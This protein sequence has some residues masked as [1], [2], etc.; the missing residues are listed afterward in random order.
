MSAPMNTAQVKADTAGSGLYQTIWRWHFYAGLIC[1]P[2]FMMLAITGALYLYGDRLE[3]VFEGHLLQAPAS[4][5]R[6]GLPAEVLI[7]KALD[8]QPG[9]AVRFTP[10][11]STG[12]SAEVGVQTQGAG[13][14]DVFLDPATG[15]L[16]GKT[17]HE[18]RLMEVI[19]HIHSLAILGDGPNLIIEVVAGW[20]V[21]LVGSGIY[22]W[23][24]RGQ[25]GGLVTLRSNPAR[26]LWWRDLHA[27][28]GILACLVLL[29]LAITGMPW[30]GFWGENYRRIVNASGLG[31][32]SSVRAA[33][34][35]SD[36]ALGA[37]S[38]GSWTLDLSTPPRS[39]SLY[40]PTTAIARIEETARR[41]GLP[42]GYV[43]RLP[44]SPGGVFTLQSYPGPATGQRVIHL[45]RYSGKVLVDVG[46][47]DYGAVSKITEIGIATHT[48]R[49][50]GF[51]NH[52]IMTAGCI[53]ILVMSLASAVMWWKR[54]PD[55][56]LGAPSL[57]GANRPLPG[58]LSVFAAFALA[59]GVL[60]PLLG[61]SILAALI[62]DRLL[63]PLLKR[64]FGL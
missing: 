15:R 59:I 20:A 35:A 46:F 43:I 4:A 42:A 22:L 29:F 47:K 3:A 45:D 38:R 40:A 24:P 44:T 64:Q 25:R 9:T 49:Q 36:A 31:M 51:V 28:T 5:G 30:S 39:M 53:A 57:M 27:V 48:G 19:S 61:L 10:P 6:P 26:R 11:P 54:R 21:L 13:L 17:P 34:V 55:G 18:S 62:L 56:G 7:A 41:L 50:F 23:W 8:A 37:V 12:R 16:L 1:L 58:G 63:P 33:S 14:V 60:F 32:P 52:F 2:F